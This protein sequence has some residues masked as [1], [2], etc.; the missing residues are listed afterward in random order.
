MAHVSPT[1][2]FGDYEKLVEIQIDNSFRLGWKKE[3]IILATNFDYSYRGVKSLVVP[4]SCFFAHRP[5][6]SKIL[7]ICYM[8]EHGMIDDSF[9]C[10]DLDAYQLQTLSPDFEGKE[11]A[12]PSYNSDPYLTSWNGGS[13]FFRPNAKDVFTQLKRIMDKTGAAEEIALLYLTKRNTKDINSKYKMLNC[14]YNLCRKT[15]P[16]RIPVDMYD[17]AD[18]PVRVI[19]FDYKNKEVYEQVRPFLGSLVE[20]F[21]KHL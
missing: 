11:L 20:I 1:K 17:Q 19:H 2:E 14:T 4:D 6:A 13:F 15:H 16:F 10:H 5:K 8:F 18:K 7:V 21:E 3:D 12:I 9:W